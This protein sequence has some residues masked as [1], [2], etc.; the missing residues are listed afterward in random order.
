MQRTIMI[1]GVCGSLLSAS[2]S[3]KEPV[4][5]VQTSTPAPA[6]EAKP[7]IEACTLLTSAE[8]ESVQGQAVQQTTPSVQSPGGLALAQCYFALPTHSNSV[9]LTVTQEAA[10]TEA[11]A[12][13][14]SWEQIFSAAGKREHEGEEKEEKQPP[15]KVEGL[16]EAAFWVGSHVGGA[17]YVLQGE[18]YIRISVGGP[19]DTAAKIDKSKRLAEFALKRL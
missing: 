1:L 9:V 11:G 6:T 19:G 13:K 12:V 15:L 2:C 3:K 14:K 8:I 10:G 5:K 4:A 16:G 7:P 18:S 17:L